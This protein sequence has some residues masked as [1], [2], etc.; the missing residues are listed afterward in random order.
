MFIYRERLELEWVEIV[1]QEKGNF[2]NVIYDI[3]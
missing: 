2:E 3:L 1:G